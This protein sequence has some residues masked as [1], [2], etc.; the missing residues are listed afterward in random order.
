MAEVY[1]VLRADPEEVMDLL[2]DLPASTPTDL[3]VMHDHL[4]LSPCT[5]HFHKL[6]L[7]CRL[8]HQ[9]VPLPTSTLLRLLSTHHPDPPLVGH[10]VMDHLLATR[11][12]RGRK[13]WICV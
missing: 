6:R 8:A 13:D 10:L 4:P 7:V 2:V 12:H 5:P 3:Q 1:L 11:Q 9:V